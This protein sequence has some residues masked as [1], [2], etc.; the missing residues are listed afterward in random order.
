MLYLSLFYLEVNYKTGER[1]VEQWKTNYK[2][3]FPLHEI[4]ALRVMTKHREEF[5]EL[6][7]REMNQLQ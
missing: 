2:Y 3:L 7:K 5:P 1:G 6:P 4:T